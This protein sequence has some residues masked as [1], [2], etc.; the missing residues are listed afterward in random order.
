MPL[1]RAHAADGIAADDRLVHFAGTLADLVE[2]GITKETLQR[3]VL[4]V[5]PAAG[6]L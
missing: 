3:K 1:Q 2:L 4:Q 6:E 5:A